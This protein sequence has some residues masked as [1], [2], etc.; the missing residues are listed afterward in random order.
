MAARIALVGN[1]VTWLE[2]HC[3]RNAQQA[4]FKMAAAKATAKNVLPD[5]TKMPLAKM[6]HQDA[7]NVLQANIAMS[8]ETVC[9]QT[10]RLVNTALT[11]L[12]LQR[13][14]CVL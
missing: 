1:S 6:L 7:S 10:V 2:R 5:V 9:V 4:S 3:A 8:Q 13:A 12:T 11:Q 14:Q